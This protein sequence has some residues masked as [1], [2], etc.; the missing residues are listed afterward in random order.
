MQ[1]SLKIDFFTLNVKSFI[2]PFKVVQLL[3][4]CSLNKDL[5]IEDFFHVPTGALRGYNNSYRYLGENLITV[6]WHSDFFDF[7]ISVNITGKGTNYFSFECFNNFYDKLIELGLTFNVTRVDLA[8]DDYVKNI[9]VDKFLSTAHNFVST[10]KGIVTNKKRETV[11]FYSGVF[12]N[13][14]YENLVFG[15]RSSSEQLFRLYDKRAEQKRTDIDYWY[16]LEL[17]L[18]SSK[19]NKVCDL[20]FKEKCDFKD[21]FF[22]LLISFFRPIEEKEDARRCD[23]KTV[24]WFQDFI[25]SLNLLSVKYTF[26][27]ELR[28]KVDLIKDKLKHL[29]IQYGKTIALIDEWNPFA[30][31]EIVTSNQKIIKN[32]IKYQRIL[33]N[34]IEILR[35]S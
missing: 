27:E 13:K 20:I 23:C 15:K 34:S 22:K 35:C 32:N 1:N 18:R 30:L 10:N 24:Q 7:G 28:K 33:S 3:C 31:K 11:T 25:D 6:S 17:E 21:V 16:R 19:A 14:L 5:E 2:E 12:N 9:P 4:D 26:K 8:Y 29:S